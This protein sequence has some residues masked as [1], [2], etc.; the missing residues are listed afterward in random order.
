MSQPESRY[1]VGIDL[2]TT[3]TVVACSAIRD[4]EAGVDIALFAVDQLVRPGEVSALPLLPSVCYQASPDELVAGNVQLPWPSSDPGG[5][6]PVVGELARLLGARSSGRLIASAKSWL[7]HAQVDRTADILPWGAPE[8]VPKQSPLAASARY[9]RHVHQAWNHHH[10]DAPLAEQQLVVTV[11]ASF[12][13]SA[14]ALT[15]EAARLAG[16]HR[17]RLLEEPQAVCYDWMWQQ[18]DGMAHQLDG[19]R[20][21]LIIDL[22]GGTLDLTLMQVEQNHGDPKLTRIAVGNHLMLGGDNIDLALAH[23]A[24][25]RLLDAG[26]R[27]GTAEWSQLVEQCRMAKERLLAAE[28]PETVRVTLLG[29]GNRL[30]GDSRSTELSRAEVRHL[31]ETGFFPLVEPDEKPLTKRSGVVEF[32]LPYAPDPAI[33]RHLAAFLAEHR[34]AAREVTGA[35][36]GVPMPDAV[37]LNGGVFQ[38]PWVVERLCNQISRWR[39][40]PPLV[41]HNQRPD[42]AVA[43]GAVV[44]DLA[45]EGQLIQRIGG[46]AARSYFV[47][48]EPASETGTAKAVCI[49]PRGT[50]EGTEI[51]LENR[52]F[53]LATGVPV[54]FD[55]IVANDD[56]SPPAGAIVDIDSTHFQI[57]PP[58]VVV[59]K[60]DASTDLPD[61][62]V[63][64]VAALSDIGT[65][66]LHCVA[67]DAPDQRWNIEFQLRGGPRSSQGWDSATAHPRLEEARECIRQI[68]GKKS[69]GMDPKAVRGLRQTL[70]KIL[71]SR[72]KWDVP[73]LRQLLMVLLEGAANR[74]RSADHERLWFNLA[75]YC[76]RPGFGYTLDEER[77]A[78]VFSLYE[79]G[80]QFVNETQNWA[81]WWTLWRRVAGGLEPASQ[82]RIFDD[83]SPFINPEMARRGNFPVLLKKRGYEDMVRLVSVLEHLPISDKAQLGT[84]LLKR[85]EKSSEPSVAWWALGRI[86]ARLPFHGSA[87]NVVPTPLVETWLEVILQRDLRKQ[88]YIAFAAV[89]LARMSGDRARDINTALRSRLAEHLR[90][91]KSPESWLTLL[92]EY[93]ELSEADETRVFGES[94]P[95]GLTLIE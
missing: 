82:K 37:L 12:D 42:Q 63:R 34:H 20:L 68:F 74:R 26:G 19:I 5:V 61:R 9:L 36:E 30:I 10:P 6:H 95:P 14:R 79:A 23:L 91:S 55:L 18:R 59:L 71:G 72:D 69:K 60:R 93:H 46:G 35:R 48:L 84:W 43:F 78:E 75:G 33:T 67:T 27:L 87:H 32:G 92:T 54:R 25:S 56:F 89:M 45:R 77:T 7:S 49:L 38:S 83:L 50:G 62:P 70:E 51:T 28:G 2:G 73:V 86:G 76:L 44:Y 21:L 13:E 39:G 16:L 57:L 81:E 53:R 64:L 11:P 29:A 4:C 31:L 24:E 58:L 47:Q 65:L 1:R 80:L 52:V 41:L 8:G 22:G 40:R 3:H 15:L 90:A 85:L 17:V 66:D 94:L 88:P